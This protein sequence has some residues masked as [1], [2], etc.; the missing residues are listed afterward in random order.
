MGIIE[1]YSEQMDDLIEFNISTILA[2]KKVVPYACYCGKHEKD[3]VVD[4]GEWE[5]VLDNSHTWQVVGLLENF[6]YTGYNYDS[7]FYT[8]YL[9]C[10]EC[11]KHKDIKY[12]GCGLNFGQAACNTL[13]KFAN[14][15]NFTK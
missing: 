2:Y 4:F 11:N 1:H 12:E 7:V 6:G 8:F 15:Y 5:P 9:K 13:I 10:P 3:Y 14:D